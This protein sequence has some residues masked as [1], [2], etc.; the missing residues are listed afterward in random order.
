M[1]DGLFIIGWI[2]LSVAI[3]LGQRAWWHHRWRLLLE[4]NR[5]ITAGDYERALQLALEDASK[6]PN[7]WRPLINA[8]SASIRL[9]D[10]AQSLEF[11]TRARN[12]GADA[13]Q[14][15]VYLA[16][17]KAYLLDET[18]LDDAEHVVRLK[19][20]HHSLVTRAFVRWMR[21]NYRDALRDCDEAI[22]LSPTFHHAYAIRAHV[23]L[24]MNDLQSAEIDNEQLSEQIAK[25]TPTAVEDVITS[26]T[27]HARICITKGD[28]Q[29][30]VDELAK[31]IE[32]CPKNTNLLTSRAFCLSAQSK[33][34]QALADLSR[35]DELAKGS[36]SRG[37]SRSNRARIA[38]IK[39]ESQEALALAEQ[40]IALCPTPSI[41]CTRAAA[42]ISNGKLDAAEK[43]LI[44]AGTLDSY[45]AEVHWWK[46][47]LLEKRGYAEQGA[48]HKRQAVDWHYTPYF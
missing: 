38:L 26:L 25:S 43:D 4:T 36:Y 39:N 41:M 32:L 33:L 45:D 5:N 11:C 21:Y 8:A 1:P 31:A 46:G 12:L 27:L 17:A 30:A 9:A 13:F 15:H 18:A 47:H 16:L 3:F 7:D 42:L 34:D 20:S 40:A 19:K 29:A 10:P 23:H 22:S 24:G 14:L 6:H 44:Q 37:Y 35:S 2:A 28:F 48:E